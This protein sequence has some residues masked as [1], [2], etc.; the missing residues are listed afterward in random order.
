MRKTKILPVF[1]ATAAALALF[2]GCAQQAVATASKTATQQIST[3]DL[4]VGLGADGRVALPVTNLNFGVDG[5]VSKICVAVGDSVKTGDLVAEL[6]DSDYQFNITSAQ[7]NVTKSQT[8]YDN[9]V[10]QYNYSVLSDQNEIDKLQ[11]TINAGF[12]D[13]SYQTAVSDAQTAL[14]RRKDDLAKAQAAADNPFDPYTY[15]NQIADAQKTLDTKQKDFDDAQAAQLATFDDYTYQ[16]AISDAKINLDRKTAALQTAV[17][18]AGAFDSYQYDNAIANAQTT[19]SRRQSDYD[20]AQKAYND[21]VNAVV[22]DSVSQ[23]LDNALNNYYLAQ[24]DYNADPTDASLKA[25][26]S[27]ANDK[28]TAAQ[29]NYDKAVSAN[30][31]AV[32]AANTKLQT[33]KNA[34]DDAQKALDNANTDK[35]RAQASFESGVADSTASARQAADDA[36]RQYDKA[37]TELERAIAANNDTKNTAYAAAKDALDAAQAS[38]D[39]LKTDKERAQAQA[40]SDAAD[41]LKSAQQAFSDAQESL[42]KAMTSLSKAKSDYAQTISDTTVSLQLKQ[43]SADMNKNSNDSVSSANFTLEEAKI[44]LDKAQANLKQVK[45]YA[46]IDGQILSISKNVGEKV[47]ASANSP[48]QMIFGT[49]ESGNNFMTLCD[50]TKIYLTASITEGDIVGVTKGMPIRVTIDAIGADVFTGTVTNI[51]SIPTTDSNG[52]TTYTVT[53]MLDDT[54]DVIKDGMNAYITFVKK[55]DKNVLLVPNKAVFMEDSL[56]YVNVVKADG[57]YEKRKVVLGLSNGVQTEV[58]SGLQAGENVLVG[59]VSS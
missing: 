59:K 11:R 50:V 2:T 20:D 23:A 12:D 42:N 19:L 29:D 32:T 38:L 35:A 52:I 26:L 39:K 8:A 10:S 34:V 7:N 17:A 57:T 9:A 16:N 31:S 4:V 41:K 18:N 40:A 25:A 1:L 43:I 48:G 46:P 33:A 15:D 21:A 49:G 30:N 28:L 55:E 51:N 13:Y 36:Q 3:G 22:S 6:D 56:Q 5:T 53:C 44:A 37:K 54:S 27:A 14:S 24:S 58:T 45:L 47:T